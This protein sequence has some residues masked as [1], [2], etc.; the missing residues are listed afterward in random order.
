MLR[1]LV[2]A[3]GCGEKRLAKPDSTGGF[4]IYAAIDQHLFIAHLFCL[5]STFG[6]HQANMRYPNESAQHASN[7]EAVRSL[8]L[9]VF[10]HE[11]LTYPVEQLPAFDIRFE[12][13]DVKEITAKGPL[14]SHRFFKAHCS[15]PKTMVL[16]NPM[17][18]LVYASKKNTTHSQ[19]PH[20]VL[21]GSSTT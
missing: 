12:E 18:I 16:A 20:R 21:I 14:F 17:N 10:N 15:V 1:W 13:L 19:I 2:A 8:A 9:R 7:R 11:P 3:S 5:D 6:H 4:L